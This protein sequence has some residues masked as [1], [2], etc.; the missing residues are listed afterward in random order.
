MDSI[1]APPDPTAAFSGVEPFTISDIGLVLG[2]LFFAPGDWLL[3]AMAVYA[4][5]VARFLELSPADY[6]GLF[7]GFVSA[8]AWLA[9]LTISF[10][11]YRAVRD[12]DEALTYRIVQL[13][14]EVR[15]NIRVTSN[16]VRFE[17]RRLEAKREERR[18]RIEPSLELYE[19]IDVSP[20]E[21]R[22][23]RAHAD[24][25]AGHAL[26]I[27][28]T[29]AALGVS[30]DEARRLVG[31]LKQLN[32]LTGA[33]GGG[34]DSAYTLTSAGAAFLLF[35]DEAPPTARRPPSAARPIPSPGRERPAERVA[36]GRIP[37]S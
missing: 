19:E 35:R 24:L 11:A 33:L 1:P 32:L 4:A 31:R 10:I 28:D 30:K 27:A 5:P 18:R 16:R 12:F 25:P 6:G 23:L 9:L 7:S 17:V 8:L 36:P 29:T 22:V 14:R 15:R 2:P 20:A 3:W 37:L 13:Y 21:L 26:P 34:G